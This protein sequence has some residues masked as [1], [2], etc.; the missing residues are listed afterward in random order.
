MT[1]ADYIVVTLALLLLPLSYVHFWHSS[2][3]AGNAVQI[4]KGATVIEQHSLATN[5]RLSV[6]G[7]LGNSILEIHDGRI[8]FIDSPCTGKVCIHTGWVK[9]VGDFAACLPNQI[10]VHIIGNASRFDAINF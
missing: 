8:R 9:Q 1:R 2:H 7:L 10:S 4:M 5:K 3:V 6:P